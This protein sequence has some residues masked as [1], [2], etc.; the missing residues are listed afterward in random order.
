VLRARRCRSLRALVVRSSAPAPGAPSPWG[1]ALGAAEGGVSRCAFLRMACTSENPHA[2]HLR[3]GFR[4]R[5]SFVGVCAVGFCHLW[6]PARCPVGAVPRVL[7]RGAASP[8]RA[9]FGGLR[10]G[11]ALVVVRLDVVPLPPRS[12]APTVAGC[13]LGGYPVGRDRWDGKRAA[14][15]MPGDHDRCFSILVLGGIFDRCFQHQ[16]ITPH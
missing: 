6:R 14:G 13:R 8:A 2:C 9:G 12:S 3:A 5:R 16:C 15:G 7:V 4:Q 11:A 10:S 1:G